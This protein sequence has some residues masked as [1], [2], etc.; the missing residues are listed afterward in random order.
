[1][2]LRRNKIHLC[3][4]K[5]HCAVYNPST[6]QYEGGRPQSRS[7]RANH[8]ADDKRMAARLRIREQR[9]PQRASV[10]GPVRSETSGEQGERSHLYRED[11]AWLSLFEE[12]VRLHSE[13]PIVDYNK[14]LVFV[15]HPVENGTFE[16]PTTDDL[17]RP[18]YGKHALDTRHRANSIFLTTEVRLCEIIA[19][20]STMNATDRG[21]T[22]I[23][24]VYRELYRMS[25][26][27][28]L[29][30]TRQR[31]HCDRT[32]YVV[33]D[34]GKLRSFATK[35]LALIQPSSAIYF[36]RPGPRDPTRKAA[37][38]ISLILENMFFTPRRALR[39]Q[40]AGIRDL[41]RIHT[42]SETIRSLIPKDPRTH[43]SQ[44]RLSSIT[45]TYILCPQCF[46][47][48]P[49]LTGDR[50]GL[51]GS[52]STTVLQCTHKKTPTSTPCGAELWHLRDFG[53][54]RKI[55]APRRKYVHNDLKAWVGRLLA[56]PGM[57]DM[58]EK[59]CRDHG[60][61]EDPNVVVD[62]IWRSKALSDL[63]DAQGRHFLPGGPGE[64][65]LV[66]SL[67]G[68]GFNPFYNKQA[69][70]LANL[71]D[72]WRP[73]VFFSRT[74]KH[75]LGILAL[76]ILVLLVADMIGARQMAGFSGSVLA[77]HF[78]TFCDLDIADIDIL[79]RQEWPSK[80]E[81]HHR[82]CA[83]AFRDAE[84]EAEQKKLFEAFG[85]R[86][87]ALLDLEYWCPVRNTVL[88]SMHILDLRLFQAHCRDLFQ[89]DT[90]SDGGDA[91]VAVDKALPPLQK[92]IVNPSDNQER[93]MKRC[94]RSMSRN[95]DDLYDIL[96][97]APR[98]VLYTICVDYN[99]LGVGHNL[100]VGTKWVLANNIC[101]WDDDRRSDAA[102]E[103]ETMEPEPREDDDDEED[104]E[105]DEYRS[106]QESAL[107]VGPRA[108]FGPVSQREEIHASAAVLADHRDATRP[109]PTPGPASTSAP[110][111]APSHEPIIG[112]KV[113]H[114]LP[115]RLPNAT[116][117]ATKSLLTKAARFIRYLG[118]D[119]SVQE[120]E[121]SRVYAQVTGQVLEYVRD[122]MGIPFHA[123]RRGHIKRALWDAIKSWAADAN[124]AQRLMSYIVPPSPSRHVLGRNIMTTVWEIMNDTQTPSWIGTVPRD[125]GTA[126]RGK[127]S[128]DHWRVICTVDNGRYKEMLDNFMD[129]VTA[130]R[131]AHMRVTSAAHIDAYDTHISRYARGISR[132]YP[133]RRIMPSL[134]AALHLGSDMAGFFG[135][136][137]SH[138]AQFYERYI[139][140]LQR[141]NT[142]Q[143][144]GEMEG[145]FMEMSSR[146]ANLRALLSDNQEVHSTV[147]EMVTTLD[148]IT[149]ED[150]RGI[151]LANMLD[152]DQPE[153]EPRPKT[154]VQYQHRLSDEEHTMLSR[155]FP[156][157]VLVPRYVDSVDQISSR[158]VRYATEGS[159]ASA[160]SSVM[161]TTHPSNAGVETQRAGSIRSIF[162]VP[163]PHPAHATLSSDFY[164]AVEEYTPSSETPGFVDPFL[165][166]GFAAGFLCEPAPRKLSLIFLSQVISH[167][168]KTPLKFS[169][170]SFIH[171]LPVDRLMLSFGPL[172]PAVDVHVATSD[173]E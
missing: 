9:T 110:A 14:P 77:H 43:L 34:T 82:R 75:R 15:N 171:V 58:L 1:M 138:S 140:T 10:L 102:T 114:T 129:L 106:Y 19:Q 111:P 107:E 26:E 153:T 131:I 55:Y 170:H 168:A 96:I 81:A 115:P 63:K 69:K 116:S 31:L 91:S 40:L 158:G 144:Q 132:L 161:F 42:G 117:D 112:R 46:C 36:S 64:V 134:H 147:L 104:E 151:R 67:A 172:V 38:L 78:C 135:P 27:K 22:L 66:F 3:Q 23:D 28:E 80:D 123:Q 137:H 18:N 150:T 142:N 94:L 169:N 160:D 8:A 141:L 163:G 100:V 95:P 88:E 73:G 33:F 90:T 164:V 118:G 149:K 76:A 70:Q 35:G 103:D 72:F 133:D 105:E 2:S 24:R 126:A 29:Q 136:V 65:R 41:L 157:G 53:G 56:C 159:R 17:I 11:T 45:H 125:W 119:E 84:S 57:E 47:L 51:E 52:A 7:T 86:W 6:N 16:A 130:V 50:P 60:P 155:L 124:N 165:P 127:L 145:T 167:F 71:N 61:P 37:A 44:F 92:R 166:F 148:A 121:H 108:T 25:L 20:I 59:S 89:I 12:E 162:R 79:D 74:Y 156:Q 21:D 83:Q 139:H 154:T 122:L 4:C 101:Q 87:S 120:E 85:I 13:S 152:P 39:T 5:T 32:G 48:Y 54:G 113:R 62:D 173:D 98:K 143:I 93:W 49:F 30:W 146:N 68:D 109:A 128:A 99:I 97:H